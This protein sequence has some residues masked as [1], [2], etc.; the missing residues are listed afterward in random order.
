[1]MMRAAKLTPTARSGRMLVTLLL[2]LLTTAT[3][4]ADGAVDYIGEDGHL[5]SRTNYT[6]IENAPQNDDGTIT[7]T[8][9]Q[10]YVVNSNISVGCF[11][12]T[13]DGA[14]NII[15]CDGK[16]IIIERIETDFNSGS[17]NIYGQGEGTGEFNVDR[18]AC[19][20]NDKAMSGNLTV[21]GGRVAIYGN[22]RG[23][24]C[25]PQYGIVGDVTMYGGSLTAAGGHDNNVDLAG[26]FGN[27]T[28]S[29]MNATDRFYANSISG[30]VTVVF[31]SG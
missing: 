15:L 13:G 16:N 11:T 12:V 10:W 1:M 2:M 6:L 29:W 20:V 5:W 30:S 24:E 18:S 21:Y 31:S 27:V 23:N 7:L 17:L 9:G 28:L 3:A 8:A 4:W 22:D 19:N 14:A 25:L 26:I